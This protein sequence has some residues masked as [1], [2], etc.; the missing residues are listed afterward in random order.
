MLFFFN[1]MNFALLHAGMM[2]D[3]I[4][5]ISQLPLFLQVVLAVIV[6]GIVFAIVKKLVKV[7]LWLVLIGLAIL[8]Y[9]TYFR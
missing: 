7:V 3:L 4:Q 2:S 5:K 6:V 9:Q 1:T 8:A